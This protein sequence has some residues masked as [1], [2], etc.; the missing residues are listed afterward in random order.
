MN[1]SSDIVH[2][3]APEAKFANLFPGAKRLEPSRRND[4]VKNIAIL[5]CIVGA[6]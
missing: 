4:A 1:S 5:E 2:A 6:S 3:T